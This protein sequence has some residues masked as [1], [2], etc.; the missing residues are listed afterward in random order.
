VDLFERYPLEHVEDTSIPIPCRHV[1]FAATYAD[2]I[3]A[4]VGQTGA[5][6]VIHDTFAVIGRVVA[7]RLRIPRVNVCAGHNVDP[8]RFQAML[9]TD[10]RVRISQECWRAADVLRDAWGIDDASP[11]CYVS[12]LSPDLNI[13]CE[14]PEFLG[15]DEKRIFEPVAFF[16][17][18]PSPTDRPDGDQGSN[19]GFGDGCASMRKVFVSFGTI[20]W[21]YYAADALRALAT[22]AET[23]A[24]IDNLRAIISLGATPIGDDAVAAL[25]RPN[26][27][28]RSY[29]DQWRILQEADAFV[30]HHGMNST[31]EAIY[32]RVPMV[33]Y[34]FFWD[35]PSLAAKCQEFGLAIRLTDGQRGAFGEHEVRAALARLDAERE[36]MRTALCRAR[37][38]ELAVVD[39]RAAVL[40]QVID[41]IPGSI[42]GIQGGSGLRS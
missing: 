2:Q 12:G 11:F 30:T 25:A 41:L 9:R 15:A 18:L 5:S 24:G 34:P 13:Y 16:G 32:H 35:Q 28:V 6:M 7:T 37:E 21:R 29:V 19:E 36:S 17:S 42:Q 38:W 20:V 14:P 31:H 4:D 3:C 40:Q 33:S 39:N 26:V 27:S 10:P 1:T 8:A 23:F 22:L